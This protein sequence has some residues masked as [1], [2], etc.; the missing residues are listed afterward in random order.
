[1]A[2]S[3]NGRPDRSERLTGQGKSLRNFKCAFDSHGDHQ[4]CYDSADAAGSVNGEAGD[5]QELIRPYRVTLGRR[6]ACL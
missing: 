3:V 2:G 6:L 1:M 4:I 5:M